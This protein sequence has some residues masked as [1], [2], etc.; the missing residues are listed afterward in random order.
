MQKIGL[1]CSFFVKRGG[2]LPDKVLPVF[3]HKEKDWEE[4]QKID[5]KK[6]KNSGGH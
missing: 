5:E 2:T 6:D 4:D 3:F 1:K